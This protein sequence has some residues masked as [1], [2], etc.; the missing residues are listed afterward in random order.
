MHTLP[1]AFCKRV[2]ILV[3]VMVLL[4]GLSLAASG[5][6]SSEGASEDSNPTLDALLDRDASAMSDE[7]IVSGNWYGRMD[8]E[9]TSYRVYH[10]VVDG[11]RV[12]LFFEPVGEQGGLV[13][14]TYDVEPFQIGE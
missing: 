11:K 13:L 2:A 6:G 9:G 14:H 1:V 4:S 12:R 5:C 10:T 8:Y 7:L 3:L